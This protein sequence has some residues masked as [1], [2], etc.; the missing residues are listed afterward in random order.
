M[1]NVVSYSPMETKILDSIP[2]DGTKI[3]T[4]DL[5]MLVYDE[6][7]PPAARQSVLD[8]CN[9]VIRKVDLNEEP[10]EILRSTARGP[11]PIYFWKVPR[12]RGVGV[13]LFTGASA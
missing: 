10:Y 6:G 4:L 5:V 8:A 3:S 12:S 1:L 7:A 11:M 13:D 2:S 9:K